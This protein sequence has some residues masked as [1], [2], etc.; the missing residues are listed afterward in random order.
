MINLKSKLSFYAEPFP[1]VKNFFDMID[2]AVEFKLPAIEIF[3]KNELGDGDEKVAMDL[4]KYADDRNIKICCFSALADLTE[5][6]AE[7]KVEKVK[8]YAKVAEILG[9]PFIHH[10]IACNFYDPKNLLLNAEER[11]KKGVLGVR[12]VYDYAKTLGVRAVYEDQGYIFNGVKNFTKFLEDVDRNVGVVADFGNIYQVGEDIVSFINATA[13]RICHVH[14]KDVT[15]TETD[16]SGAGMHTL[17]DKYMNE[18]EIGKGHVP[19]KEGID[20]VKKLGYDGYYS[21]EFGAKEDGSPVIQK[22]LDLLD[23]LIV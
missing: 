3:G 14:I 19:L 7:Q 15:I 6:D 17:F 22:T 11:Y 9:S 21:I 12:E 2:A 1:R 4:R 16:E 5:D 18:V 10:T 8:R 20:L 23:S 13:D